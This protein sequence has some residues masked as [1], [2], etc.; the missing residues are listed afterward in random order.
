MSYAFDDRLS[1]WG[2]RDDAAYDL[3]FGGDLIT[4]AENQPVSRMPAHPATDI[5]KKAD[6]ALRWMERAWLTG[7]PLVALLY[8]FFALEAMLGDKS[9]KLKAH[10]LAFR[11]TMLSHVVDGNF[12]HPSGT[13]FL[14]DTVRSGAVHG[15]DAP[16]VEW[17]VVHSFAWDVRRT[18]NQYLTVAEKHKYARRAR[19][20]KF[21]DEHPDR[22]RLIAW[23]REGGGEIWTKFLD[24]LEGSEDIP[25]GEPT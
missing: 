7:E 19:L 23:L 5:A 13:W 3:G 9:E 2:T 18:L 4:K 12:P 24:D 11:Q 17:K 6:L 15:E 1:G 22:P 20:L 10:G 8:L 14:Y 21:L 25:G 16:D